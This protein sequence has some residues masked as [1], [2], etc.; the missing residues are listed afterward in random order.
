MKQSSSDGSE[1]LSVHVGNSEAILFRWIKRHFEIIMY[2]ICGEQIDIKVS[3][4]HY[5][6]VLKAVLRKYDV[7]IIDIRISDRRRI[8]NNT[9]E[10]QRTFVVFFNI[11]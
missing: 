7:D 3:N 5:I 8:V 10:I 6:L 1:F 4:D 9:D 11:E 2:T